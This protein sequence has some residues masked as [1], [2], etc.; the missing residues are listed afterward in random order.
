MRI[1]AWL[2]GLIGTDPSVLRFDRIRSASIDAYDLVDEL[3]RGSARVSAWNAYV[4]RT[5]A[6]KLISA[7]SVGEY[8]SADTESIVFELYELAGRWIEQARG[9]APAAAG[10]ALSQPPLPH[11]HTPIRSQEQLVGMRET[12][13]VLRVFLTHDLESFHGTDPATTKLRERLTAIN[14]K[15]D[16]A[17]GLWLRRAP[18]EL[19]GGI[20]DA[21]ADGLDLAYALGQLLA[22]QPATP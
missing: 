15:V 22:Q 6:D 5:Y 7:C 18:D 4:L 21:L 11:W 9:P 12:L 20:G 19:R 2:L 10:P 8:V 13:D 3:P 17:D 16:A 1:P 14:A